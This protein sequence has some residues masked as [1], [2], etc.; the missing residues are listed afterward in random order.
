M[1]RK[2]TLSVTASALAA[3]LTGC[4]MLPPALGGTGG[5]EEQ[6]AARE[7]AITA[8]RQERAESAATPPAGQGT[9]A[10]G[11]D[12]QET[13][14]GETAP[15]QGQVLASRKTRS[16]GNDLRLDV[17]GLVRQ[18]RTVTLNWTV[19][20]LGAEKDTWIPHQKLGAEMLDFTVSGVSLIDPVNAKRY[21]VA[22]NGTG[23]EAECVCSRTSGSSVKGGSSLEFYA[24]FGAPP[25]DVAKVNIE[26]PSIGVI[27]DVPI[28]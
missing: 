25:A 12:A 3:L 20:N 11:A 19:T 27:T 14:V 4:G 1:H 17:T 10:Q 15:P 5:E 26:F 23:K 28:S 21:R 18:G 7:K 2:I 9:A 22:R 16:E 24:V 13:P 8:A 6:A